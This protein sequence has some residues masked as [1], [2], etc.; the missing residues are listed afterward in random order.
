VAAKPSTGDLLD[1]ASFA[2]KFDAP[3][4]TVGE[5][6]DP[7]R[8]EDGVVEVGWWSPSEVVHAWERALYD[9]HIIDPDSDY[10]AEDNVALVNE[11]IDDPSL[12]ADLDLAALRRALTFLAR[13][14]R[15]TGGG[16]FESAFGS[17]MA[18]AMMRRLGGLAA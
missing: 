14:Q 17:G 16:W 13:A 15:H 1:V 4:F 18:Q 5:W 6:H 9:H 11:S 2:D 7:V 12:V 3:D 8:H 10:L